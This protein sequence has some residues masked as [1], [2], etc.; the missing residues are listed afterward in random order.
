MAS[1]KRSK[2]MYVL[3]CRYHNQPYTI[4]SFKIHILMSFGGILCSLHCMQRNSYI[5]LEVSLENYF[6]AL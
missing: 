2:A 1:L 5:S 3:M 4:F 6:A